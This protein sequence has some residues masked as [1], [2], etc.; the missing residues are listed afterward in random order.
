[1]MLGFHYMDYYHTAY[2]M[3]QYLASLGYLVLSVNYRTG[4]MY[5]RHFREPADGGWRGGAEYKDIVAAGRFLKGLPNIDP[6]RIGLW[7]G[8]Y[9]GY[10]TAMGLAHNSDLFAAGVDLHGVHDW[11]AF[12]EEFPKD[13]PDRDAALNLAF[14]SSPDAAISTWTSPVLLI[15]GDDDRNVPFSQTVDLLQRLRAQKVHVE[16]LVLP[17]EVHGFLMWK[18]WMGAYGATAEFFEREM[19]PR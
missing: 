15:Q 16:E 4:I 14:Q 18:S 3:N 8:S 7:G 13:A 9:G 2:A 17:D 6:K 19:P 12:L 5:G 10:L 11:S 1:M